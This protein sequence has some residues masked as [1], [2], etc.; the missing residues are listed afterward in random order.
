MLQILRRGGGRRKLRGNA[1]WGWVARGEKILKGFG[2]NLMERGFGRGKIRSN[3]LAIE[4][5]SILRRVEKGGERKGELGERN[6]F[7]GLGGK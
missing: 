5:L 2:G 1:D 6:D 4:D 3:G 7:K